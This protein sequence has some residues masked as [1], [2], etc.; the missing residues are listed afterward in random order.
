MEGHREEQSHLKESAGV[1]KNEMC[2]FCACHKC[3]VK[4]F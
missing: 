2:H 3:I 4:Y 1:P